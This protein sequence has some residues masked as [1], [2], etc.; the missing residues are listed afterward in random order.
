MVTSRRAS[1]ARSAARV[2]NVPKGS[3]DDF[4]YICFAKYND[5]FFHWMT[6]TFSDQI[7]LKSFK[8]LQSIRMKVN[9]LVVLEVLE[10]ATTKLIML[11]YYVFQNTVIITL[12][13]FTRVAGQ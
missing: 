12:L 1:V 7:S 9:R 2:L 4:Q 10:I 6:P 13:H 5:C 3:L 11:L 8:P